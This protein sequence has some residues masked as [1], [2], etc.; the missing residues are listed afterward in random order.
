MELTWQNFWYQLKIWVQFELGMSKDLIHINFGIGAFLT[1]TMFLRKRK[2]G[3]LIAWMTVACLQ[4]LN[5]LLD[6][7]DWIRWTGVVNWKETAKDY[8][9]TLF[10]PTVMLISWKWIGPAR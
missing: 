8:F 2:Y 3:F 9:I 10:W 5:E 1:A 7:R 4:T 6:A